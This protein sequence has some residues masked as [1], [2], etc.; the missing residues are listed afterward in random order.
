M[1]LQ[2]EYE[3]ILPK[4]YL[5][6]DGNLHKEGVMRLA[7]A[8]DE[9]L[10]M[11]DARVQQNPAYLTIILLSRVITRLGEVKMVNTRVIEGLFAE[12]LSYLQGIYRRINEQGS[13]T[14]TTVCPKC[15]HQFV[16]EVEPG[17]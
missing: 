5:D 6:P 11:K 17:E 3:F 14:L 16:V 8:G 1:A 10:P 4:G 15:D 12:D 2:T 13:N 9:I 7:T